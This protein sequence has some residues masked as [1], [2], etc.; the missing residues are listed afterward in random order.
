MSYE[1]KT[2]TTQREI[3]R[4]IKFRNNIY[5]KDLEK[6]QLCAEF[7]NKLDADATHLYVAKEQQLIGVG[8]LRFI[9]STNDE[10]LKKF[11][12]FQFDRTQKTA[13]SSRLVT[14]KDFR[15]G[16]LGVEIMF[17]IYRHAIEASTKILL[18]EVEEHLVRL[19]ERIGC[20]LLEKTTNNLGEIRYQ[21]QANL[22]DLPYLE[23]IQSPLVGILKE[24]L[25][26]ENCTRS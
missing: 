10:E 16:R 5:L 17:A 13:I 1:I 11:T 20:F 25:H 4:I 3:K 14:S 18:I 24:T 7:E 12:N 9:H 22:L 23:S 15:R 19:Y 6:P 26:S 21:M 2:A 8:R